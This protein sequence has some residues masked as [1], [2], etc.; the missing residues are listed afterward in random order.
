MKKNNLIIERDG[1]KENY[2]ILLNVSADD[3]NYIVYTR[4]EQNDCGDTIAYAANYE[5]S[6]GKQKI[7]PI[8][9]EEVLEFLD[10]ILLQIQTNM[11]GG[12]H[13]WVNLKK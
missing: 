11:N 13:I 9:D 6:D 3:T 10:G 5:F 2:D 1:G 12:E 4:H 7:T 8:E